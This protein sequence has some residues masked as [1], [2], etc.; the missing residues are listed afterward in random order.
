M[1]K[2]ANLVDLIKSFLTSI[3]YYLVLLFIILQK[4]ASIQ[5]M[6]SLSKFGGDSIHFSF[7]FIIRA[8]LSWRDR[9]RN[10]V[11]RKSLTATCE[12][13][14]CSPARSLKTFENRENVDAFIIEG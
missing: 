11:F 7:H 12:N 4:S 13:A 6:T 3:Y 8:R 14:T 9:D 1:Q 2:Y 5:P 10:N